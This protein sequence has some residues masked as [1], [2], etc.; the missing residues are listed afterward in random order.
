MGITDESLQCLALGE[1]IAIV[2]EGECGGTEFSWGD[3]LDGADGF[4]AA[5]DGSETLY[6]ANIVGVGRRGLYRVA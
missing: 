6:S 5:Y 2:V 3:E 1:E 4:A